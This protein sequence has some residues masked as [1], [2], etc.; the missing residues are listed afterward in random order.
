M[1]QFF[2]LLVVFAVCSV[3]FFESVKYYKTVFVV[4]KRNKQTNTA[5]GLNTV[6]TTHAGR[7]AGLGQYEAMRQMYFYFSTFTLVPLL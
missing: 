7:P 2:I 3:W 5:A 6:E 1:I 4:F